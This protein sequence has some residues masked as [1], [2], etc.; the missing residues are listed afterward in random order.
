MIASLCSCRRISS[1]PI[2]R[3]ISV[4][5]VVN[6]RLAR[7]IQSPNVRS[8]FGMRSGP[9]TNSA[10]TQIRASS[11]K[12]ISNIRVVFVRV[13]LSGLQ[14]AFDHTFLAGGR[15]LFFFLHRG[16]ESLDGGAEIRAERLQAL[17]SE[18]Q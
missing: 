1:M 17:R 3:S 2:S 12:L 16:T 11:E 14:F 13:D 5:I 6:V 4:R 7:P 8:A 9:R 15:R 10:I 18:Q